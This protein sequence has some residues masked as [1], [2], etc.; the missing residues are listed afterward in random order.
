MFSPFANSFRQD[1]GVSTRQEWCLHTGGSGSAKA[2][3]VP[4]TATTEQLSQSSSHYLH[5]M[6][7]TVLPQQVKQAMLGTLRLHMVLQ[8]AIPTVRFHVTCTADNLL[9][10]IAPSAP[11]TRFSPHVCRTTPLLYRPPC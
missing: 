11:S 8:S 10:L 3:G 6:V 4:A 7:D 9:L 5:Q 1:S 2:E